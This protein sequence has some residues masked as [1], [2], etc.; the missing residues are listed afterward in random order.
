MIF[1][2][3]QQPLD[4]AMT[5]AA[6]QPVVAV[7]TEA[8]SLHSYFDKV[9]LIQMSVAGEDLIID[10]LKKLDLG[11]FGA[12]LAERKTQKVLHG[13]D[14]DLRIL[15]RDF[16]FTIA[17]VVDTSICAQ[18][19]GYEAI[20][21]AALVERHFG[22]QLDKSH[23]RADW[24]MRPLPRNMLEYAATDTRYLIA[25]AEKLRAELEALGRWEWA[26]EEFARLENVRYEKEETEEPFRRLKG[27]GGLD[28]RTLAI[29]QRLYD[30]RDA[31]ARKADRPP[32]KIFSNEIIIESAKAKPKTAAELEA[33][34]ALPPSHRQRYGRDI[35]RIV[36]ESQAL[37]EDALPQ[38]PESRPW[39]RDK[40]LESRVNKLKAARDKVVKELKIDPAVLAP[41]HVLTAIAEAGTLD[42][43]AMREWQKRVVGDALLAA[44]K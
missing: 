10:P 22:V 2:D 11:G 7:D 4:A 38:K 3:Q 6:A 40:A 36:R 27:L 25:L 33:V 34:K 37:S 30:Y 1:I 17:N 9:C 5:R 14:Y 8:D 18:L 13:A 21:L 29:V 19:L 26:V 31:L 15:N 35:V 12:L 28:R 42:V 20:G 16:G 32:F 44:L 41:R 23:Q 24:A 39:M 43:P